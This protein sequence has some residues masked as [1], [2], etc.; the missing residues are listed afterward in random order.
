MNRD[1]QLV[2][3]SIDREGSFQ[4]STLSNGSWEIVQVQPS[5]EG[6]LAL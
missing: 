2:T 5:Q 3:E 4:D 6:A 1:W